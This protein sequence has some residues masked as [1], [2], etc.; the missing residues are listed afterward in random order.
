VQPTELVISDDSST[1]ATL[2]IA[3]AFASK[4]P[5]AVRIERNVVRLGY[6][7]NF[8][9]AA[10]MCRSEIIAFCDQDD[11]WLPEK[12]ATCLPA[13]E[14]EEVLLAYHNATV[15]DAGLTPIGSLSGYAAP[16]ALNPPRSIGPWRF[17]LGFTL[18]FRKTLLSLAGLWPTSVDFNRPAEKEGHDLWFFFLASSLGSIRYVH[19]PLAL[20]RQHGANTFGVGWW[21]LTKSG[22]G[23]RLR[24]F[25]DVDWKVL[26]SQEIAAGARAQI[27][28]SMQTTLDGNLLE[29]AKAAAEQYHNLETTY[30]LR[31]EMYAAARRYERLRLMCGLISRGGYGSNRQGGI[32]QKNAVRD[33]LG[34]VIAGTRTEPR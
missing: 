14:S 30:Q 27:L 5:F 13:F 16:G 22:L 21:H 6:R 20:Y 11:V 2:D 34:S 18:L 32:G 33:F 23:Q 4:A 8:M 24:G 9:Q 3:S 26:R 10:N 25:V 12:L 7:A 28:R 17:A 31:R 1:D 29:N 19:A 15:V